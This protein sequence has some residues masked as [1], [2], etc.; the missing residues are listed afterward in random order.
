MVGVAAPGEPMNQ[1]VGELGGLDGVGVVD[2]VV[3]GVPLGPGVLGATTAPAA[4]RSIAFF[5]LST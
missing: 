3:E 4:A 5:M 1:P 2:G